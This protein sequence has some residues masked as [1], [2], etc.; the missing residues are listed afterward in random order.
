MVL[1]FFLAGFAPAGSVLVGLGCATWVLATPALAQGSVA[2]LVITGNPLQREQWAIPASTVSGAELRERGQGSLGETLNGL[3]GVS[4]SYF[5]PQASRPLIRGLDGDRIRVLANGGALQDASSLSDDHAVPTDALAVERIEVLR[6]PASLLYG[7][8]A[9]GGVVNVIDQRIARERLHGVQGRAQWQAASGNA[10]RS[11]AAL[12]ETGTGD[13]VL[14]VDGFERRSGDVKVPL[15]LSCTRPGAPVQAQRICNSAGEARGAA[16][17]LSWVGER[18]R[19]GVSASTHRSDY[20]TVADDQV[21]IGLQSD[22]YALEGEWRAPWAGVRALELRLGQGDYR[23]QEFHAG[24]PETRFAKRSSDLRLQLQHERLGPLEGVLGLQVDA[25]DFGARGEE[26]FAPASRT[27]TQALFAHEE[28]ATPWGQWNLGARAEQ[29]QVRSLGLDGVDRFVPGERQFSPSSAAT[30]ALWRLAPGWHLR[31][32]WAYTERAPRDHELFAHGPHLATVAYDIG[33]TGLRVERSRSADL[34]L[35]WTRGAERLSASI[36]QNHF[37]NYIA[38]MPTGRQRDAQGEPAFGAGA[39]TEQ[40]YRAV[41]ARFEGFELGGL[42]RLALPG[43]TLDLQWRADA[44][45][46]TDLASGQPLPRIAPLRWGGTLVYPLGP[47]TA[48][49][50]FDH[51]AAQS[52]V[53]VQALPTSAYTLWHAGLSWRQRLERSTLHW[54]ARADNLGNALAYSATSVLTSTAP[55]RAPLPGRSLKLGV[56]WLF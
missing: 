39:L 18:A 19:L 34:G 5:G 24:T 21:T 31:A 44:V 49:W 37:A 42:H 40:V 7:G 53:P 14:H 20:G 15:S 38:L 30:S 4:S 16:L 46:A 2:E 23:H 13:M 25:A 11:Q 55:G 3:P 45:R 9:I 1:R 35:E 12:L 41:P 48:R 8:S 33:N 10:E 52:R 26:A 6:G 43:A 27:H 56:Q 17:G 22:R 51:V 32:G 28:W 36:Y 54:F 29:V 50:G 47:W